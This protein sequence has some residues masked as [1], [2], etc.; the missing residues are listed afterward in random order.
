MQIRVHG[1][2]YPFPEIDTI[3][4]R[5][6]KIVKKLTGL[7]LGEYE[8]AFESGDTDMMIAL[9]A[10]AVHRDSNRT[11]LDYLLDLKLDDIQFVTEEADTEI[12]PAQAPES[13]DNG[14]S[15][16]NENGTSDPSGVP[17]SSEST[18]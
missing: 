18:A 6:A 9:A 10:V 15:S 1:V 13:S 16:A 3:T 12:P 8:E 7:R 11:D 2:D 5:E 17:A 4:Y 14:N